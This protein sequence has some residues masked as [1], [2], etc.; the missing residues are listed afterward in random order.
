M[1]ISENFSAPT[2]ATS[3]R[4]SYSPALYQIKSAIV[5]IRFGARSKSGKLAEYSKWGHPFLTSTKNHV[6]DLPPPCPHAS[7]WAGPPPL[8]GRPHTVDMKYTPLS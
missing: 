6:F 3:G 1:Q 8:C 4:P 5:S 2:K 7:T